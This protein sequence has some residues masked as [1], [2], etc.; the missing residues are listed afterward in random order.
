M[1]QNDKGLLSRLKEHQVEFVIIGGVCGVFHG[2][3]LVT[4]DLDVCCR[5]MPENLR[6]IENA[7][8]D[9]HPV[10]RMTPN[11]LP[12]ELN[13]ELCS[14]LKNLCL[15]TDIG[16]LDCLG[17]VAGVGDY[18]QALKRSIIHHLSYG[19]FHILDID[20]LIAAKEAVGRGRDLEAVKEL[21]IIKDRNDKKI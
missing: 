7:L 18:E 4:Q 20:A 21:R 14:R 8:K 17:E 2:I 19:A 12:L 10:H 11:K 9:L 1:P 16:M 6:R 5:F 13:D 3:S 15:Q